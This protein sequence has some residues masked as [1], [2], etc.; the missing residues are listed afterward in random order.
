MANEWDDA[1]L[2]TPR[3]RP[4]AE[5]WSSLMN[6]TLQVARGYETNEHHVLELRV[7]TPAEPVPAHLRD[8]LERGLTAELQALA[9][10]SH[11]SL[12]TVMSGLKEGLAHLGVEGHFART[13]VLLFLAHRRATGLTTPDEHCEVQRSGSVLI[14]TVPRVDQTLRGR[15]RASDLSLIRGLLDGS[16]QS[17]IAKQRGTSVRTVAHLTGS[18]YQRLRV[19]GRKALIHRLCEGGL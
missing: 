11:A 9:I 4:L 16:S 2:A 18:L 10:A 5:L 8:L 6:G 13:P 17:E 19:S 15:L 7:R 3:A 1:E 12:S 14:A